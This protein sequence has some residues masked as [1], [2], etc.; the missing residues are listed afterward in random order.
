MGVGQPVSFEVDAYPARSSMVSRYI[1]PGLESAQRAL[2]VEAS[3]PNP[4]GELKPGLF[5]TA[6]IEQPAK[7]PAVLV[8]AAAVQTSAGTSRVYVVNGD[9]VDERIVTVGQAPDVAHGADGAALV[10]I[11]NGLK[12]GDRVATKNVTTLADGTK[13]SL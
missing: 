2:T 12:A 7:T 10:E 3:V 1:S 11:T 5:A 4:T 6:L 8:P 9:H 13:V